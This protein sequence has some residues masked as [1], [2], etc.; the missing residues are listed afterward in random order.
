MATQ[1]QEMASLRKWFSK[2][3]ADRGQVVTDGNFYGRLDHLKVDANGG[4]RL[5]LMCVPVEQ[6]E[7][8]VN[9][10]YVE[11]ELKYNNKPVKVA[12]LAISSASKKA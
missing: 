3:R 2:Y 8:S 1:N 7:G 12:L 10:V 4:Y 6:K 11:S 5:M 9:P